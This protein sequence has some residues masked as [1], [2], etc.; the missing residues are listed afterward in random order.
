MS[1]LIHGERVGRQGKLR[2][3]ASAIIFDQDREK[4]LLTR[5]T[6]NGRWCLPGGGMDP[7]ES[8]EE[9]CVREVLEETGLAVRVTRLVGVYTSPNILVEYADG[10][11]IQP[12]AF[13]FEAEVV[14]GELGLSDE[15]TEYGYIP[16][17]AFDTIDLME[18][19]KQRIEDAL[20]SQP[21][22][23]FR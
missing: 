22:A 16:V 19:H 11:R 13:S 10:N 6:D 8:A 15:T 14:G 1:N 7:G 21:A 4:V 17:E 3:G 5:R 9:T 18:H 12:V 20:Q 23:F 2:P